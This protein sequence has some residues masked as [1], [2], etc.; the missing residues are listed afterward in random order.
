[1]KRVCAFGQV[2]YSTVLPVVFA[3]CWSL[4][5]RGPLDAP[6]AHAQVASSV[7]HQHEVRRRYS[8][9]WRKCIGGG[10]RHV[11]FQTQKKGM[12]GAETLSAAP[13]HICMIVNHDTIFTASPSE[14]CKASAPW[15]DITIAA[16]C[17]NRALAC[18]NQMT[19]LV[20]GSPTRGA[21]ASWTVSPIPRLHNN[22]TVVAALEAFVGSQPDSPC[23]SGASRNTEL[24]R[25]N[26]GIRLGTKF[27]SSCTELH[28]YQSAMCW[29]RWTPTCSSCRLLNPLLIRSRL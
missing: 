27:C 12:G 11:W 4:G 6:S 14:M 9:I 21:A 26:L 17:S 2:L 25:S 16:Q 22:Q 3:A 19:L 23:E 5:K 18:A 24:T 1:M 28:Y 7:E 20:V 29:A 8:S 13:A 10:W 15:N